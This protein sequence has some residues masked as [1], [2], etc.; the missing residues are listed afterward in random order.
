MHIMDSL[1]TSVGFGF[2]ANVARSVAVAS[3]LSIGEAGSDGG[4]GAAYQLQVEQD[5]RWAT[6]LRRDGG[7][8]PCLRTLHRWPSASEIRRIFA[9][10]RR[11]SILAFA[12]NRRGQLVFFC[13]PRRA[14]QYWR[15][16]ALGKGG[17]GG[18]TGL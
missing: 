4:G 9:A 2:G 13:A 16:G 18:V 8:K 11:P 17:N 14:V 15:S 12:L 7:H 3:L 10:L 6:L 1:W 5:F